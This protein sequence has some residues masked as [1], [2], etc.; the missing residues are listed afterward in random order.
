M[1][2]Y[3]AVVVVTFTVLNR[4]TP[5]LQARCQQKCTGAGHSAL[6]RTLEMNFKIFEMIINVYRETDS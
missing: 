5:P 3:A 1:Q 2:K 6:N 4:A